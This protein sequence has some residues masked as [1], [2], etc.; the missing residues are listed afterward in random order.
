M[1]YIRKF[2]RKN[3]D[4]TIKTYY[5]EVESHW[6]NGKP[7]QRYIRPLGTDPNTPNTIP[8]DDMHFGYIATRL[9][10]GNLTANELIEMV[11][12]M[13]HR[14]P[15]EDLEAIGIKY[16]FKKNNMRLSLYPARRSET[17][18][19]ARNVERNSRSKR[20]IPER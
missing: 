11:E 16:D 7:V 14:V 5:A 8:L 13:G 19:T 3:K 2:V 12:K 10:Q 4:G 20:H 1:A 18:S 15:I 6:I 17:Q 9:M